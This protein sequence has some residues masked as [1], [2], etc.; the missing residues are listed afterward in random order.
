MEMA[1][2]SPSQSFFSDFPN[3][4]NLKLF[5]GISQYLE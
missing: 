3:L 1:A 5:P 4:D 2:P